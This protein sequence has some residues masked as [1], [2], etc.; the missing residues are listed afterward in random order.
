MKTHFQTY[1]SIK[2]KNKNLWTNNTIEGVGSFMKIAPSLEIFV[3]GLPTNVDISNGNPSQKATQMQKK[4]SKWCLS[5][6]WI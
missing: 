1:S 3:E 4:T 6:L 5:H 2:Y